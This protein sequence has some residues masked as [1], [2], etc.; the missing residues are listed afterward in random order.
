MA[1]NV[2]TGQT[3]HNLTAEH[4]K[5]VPEWLENPAVAFDSDTVAGALVFIAP[6]LLNGAPIIVSVMPKEKQNQ[7]DVHMVTNAYD[8]DSGH[9]PVGRWVREGKLR[10]IDKAKS[11]ELLKSSGLQ[12]PSMLKEI[13][14]TGKKYSLI[15]I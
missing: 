3:N 10:Y 2:I 5:K 6:E 8:K 7:L 1:G 4:C 14:H 9:V 12:L 13:R 15:L 11:R